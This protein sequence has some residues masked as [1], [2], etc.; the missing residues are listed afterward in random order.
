MKKFLTVALASLLALGSASA[1]AADQLT[2]TSVSAQAVDNV[3][4]TPQYGVNLTGSY[5]IYNGLFGR[6]ETQEVWNGSVHG[7]ETLVGGGYHFDFTDAA[8]VYGIVSGVRDA[9]AVPSNV[10]YGVDGEVGLRFIPVKH[11]E[12]GVAVEQTRLDITNGTA[13]DFSVLKAHAAYQVAS[14]L[15]FVVGYQHDQNDR[16]HALTAGATLLF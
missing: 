2:Y 4:Q 11:L 9:S 14:N 10:S 3:G 1:F 13:R 12:L 15:E 7:N 6:V 16:D 5:N 8:S